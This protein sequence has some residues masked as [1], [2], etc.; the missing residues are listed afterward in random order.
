MKKKDPQLK[1]QWFDLI[2]K[3]KAWNLIKNDLKTGKQILNKLDNYNIPVYIIPGN[4][5]Y[6]SKEHGWKKESINYYNKSLIK[7]LKNVKNCHNKLVKFGKFNIIGYGI[8]SSPEV[9]QLK[10]YK[11]GLTKK[12]LII[13][14]EFRVDAFVEILEDVELGLLVFC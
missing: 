5:D 2:G 1:T 11:K 7:N 4:G 10:E 6:C 8:N 14:N 12:E 3:K 13:D 9:P